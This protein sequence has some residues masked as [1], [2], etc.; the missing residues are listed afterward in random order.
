SRIAPRC[1]HATK[2]CF[3]A[4]AFVRL[5]V[6]EAS[7]RLTHGVRA[8]CSCCRDEW[9]A[10]PS[11]RNISDLPHHGRSPRRSTN[12]NTADAFKEMPIACVLRHGRRRRPTTAPANRTEHLLRR[13]KRFRQ[14]ETGQHKTPRL[15][16]ATKP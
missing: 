3:P 5:D 15:T 13:Q 1:C 4:G 2:P 7:A 10:E 8:S 9:C 6:L 16:Q 11:P 14:G 12:V